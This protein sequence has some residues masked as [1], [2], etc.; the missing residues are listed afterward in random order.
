[1]DI[2]AFWHGPELRPIDRLCLTSMVLTGQ[3]VDLYSYGR[4]KNLP[5]GLHL[6]DA[7]EIV[8][9][10]L[11]ENVNTG[12]WMLCQFSDIFRVALMK[13]QRGVWLDTD[14][15]LTKQF[16]PRPEK[17][18]LAW[19]NRHRFGV[20][21]L[22]FPPN[23]PIIRDFDDYL[24]SHA[25]IPPWLGFRRR[26]LRPLLHRVKGI[27]SVPANLGITIFANDGISRLFRKH[28]LAHTAAPKG[29]FYYWNGKSASRVYNPE[30]GL[31]PL[32]DPDF[33]GFHFA[34]KGEDAS[35]PPKPGSFFDW[36]IER[37]K[38]P[39]SVVVRK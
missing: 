13:H 2:C 8:P 32:K 11:L 9:E 10:P 24:E 27:E 1:M 5:D 20:S 37:T 29:T 15:Y 28:G 6:R 33:I 38:S 39:R 16:H 7:R 14:I 25:S 18:F 31:E 4:I 22:Y 21:A 17:H 34:D 36:A 3:T 19:E 23:S 30:Y 12:K 26:V 35:K